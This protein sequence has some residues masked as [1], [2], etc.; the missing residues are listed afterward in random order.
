MASCV[1]M[2]NPVLS[3]TASTKS[4][5]TVRNSGMACSD[6]LTYN[7][8]TSVVMSWPIKT[9]MTWLIARRMPQIVYLLSHHHAAKVTFPD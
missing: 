2:P 9:A 8:Y 5:R 1:H 4:S 6:D 7:M 3:T